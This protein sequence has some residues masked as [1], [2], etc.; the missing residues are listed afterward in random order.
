MIYQSSKHAVINPIALPEPG[1]LWP[2]HPRG[3]RGCDQNS[4]DH[5]EPSLIRSCFGSSSSFDAIEGE[6]RIH[7]EFV[8]ERNLKHCK[9]LDLAFLFLFF[10]KKSIFFSFFLQK[11][12]SIL[13]HYEESAAT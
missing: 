5:S 9:I 7:G 11:H 2:H 10:P 4:G 8:R 12:N 13:R 1:C 6:I 3:D